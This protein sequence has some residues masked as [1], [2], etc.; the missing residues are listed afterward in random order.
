MMNLRELEAIFSAEKIFTQPVNLPTREWNHFTSRHDQVKE[1]SI[2]V[3]IRGQNFDGH[4]KI[5]EVLATGA[6]LI[7][8]EISHPDPRVIEVRDSRLAL[9]YL[10]AAQSEYT[11]RNLIVCG[12]TGT[13]GKT[14]TT[15]I[16]ESILKSAGHKVG[17][18]GTVEIRLDGKAIPS[19]HTTPGPEDLHRILK[20]MKEMG[21]TAVIM[22]VSSHALVQSRVAGVF[23]DAL[24]FTN[25][26]P[27]HL[28]FHP[29]LEDYFSAKKLLFSQ[30]WER[31]VRFGAKKPKGSIAKT[32]WGE[33]LFHS[34]ADEKKENCTLISLPSD[35]DFSSGGIRGTFSEIEI[36]SD[37]IGPFNAENLSVAIQMAHDIGVSP[38]DIKKGVENLKAVPGRLEK[39]I[40]PE[41]RIILVDYAHK[42]DALEKVL[43]TLRGLVESPNR[44]FT[45]IGCGGDRDRTK[46]PVMAEIAENYSDHVFL[47]S[48]NPRTEDPEAILDEMEK[49]IRKPEKVTRNPDRK[50]AIGLSILSAK[51][52][53][54][55][56]IAGKGH[57]TY[58]IIGKES[59]PFDDLEVARSFL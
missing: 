15:F 36:Q 6:S 23:F 13:S 58:Q 55:I 42:P 38:Q 45:V 8:S 14:T 47:T 1:N 57:E 37:L 16:L 33:K 29:T 27:E 49:G 56:L 19:T 10:A 53:D 51:K 32:T 39:V 31:S 9:A 11:T 59:F 18:I 21:C 54:W 3:A 5:D 48:D 41:G 7:F 20:E 50:K 44:L 25:L 40:D 24:G 34:I 12:V 2:F 22:E 52:G 26:S 30:E 17:L 46:R 4:E 28:D 35:L 43:K